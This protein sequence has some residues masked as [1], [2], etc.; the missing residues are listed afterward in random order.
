MRRHFLWRVAEE[1]LK[2]L[3]FA[4]GV[5]HHIHPLQRAQ[6]S[7]IFTFDSLLW[8]V[9]DGRWFVLLFFT[10]SLID[11][12]RHWLLI[13]SGSRAGRIPFFFAI[14]RKFRLNYYGTVLVTEPR[15]IQSLRSHLCFVLLLVVVL[16]FF[17]LLLLLYDTLL[18]L[19]GRSARF[20]NVHRRILPVCNIS[21]SWFLSFIFLDVLVVL[22][23]CISSTFLL[24]FRSQI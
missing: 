8:D 24:D 20:L 21:K 2:D 11:A 22:T 18:R 16:V 23:E 4:L 17:L 9:S 7:D 12:V 10:I 3:N 15:I 6:L 19:G 5:V 1:L 13:L 14:F